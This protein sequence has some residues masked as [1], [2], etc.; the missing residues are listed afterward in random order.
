[1]TVITMLIVGM[2]LAEIAW[3]QPDQGSDKKGKKE[4]YVTIEDGT[5][6]QIIE[7]VKDWNECD[8]YKSVSPC[9]VTVNM[10]TVPDTN[11]G[12]GAYPRLMPRSHWDVHVKPFIHL[13]KPEATGQAA[14][15][16]IRT[17]PFVTCTVSAVPGAPGR[18]LSANIGSLL[19]AVAGI[20]APAAPLGQLNEYFAP[21]SVPILTF[22]RGVG[23]TGDTALDMI[24]DEIQ[25]RSAILDTDYKAI[26][27]GYKNFPAAVKTYWKFTFNDEAAADEAIKQLKIK[28]KALRDALDQFN[29]D[30]EASSASEAKLKRYVNP[31]TGADKITVDNAVLG[32]AGDLI[33]VKA[34]AD[35]IKARL[36]D[37][38]DRQKLVLQVSDYLD[39]W[40]TGGVDEKT[41]RTIKAL[42]MAYFSG[43]TVTETITCKDAITKDPA[44][45]NIIFAAYYE[46]LLHIDISVGAI[47]SLLG[48]RQVGSLTTPFTPAQAAACTTQAA[49]GSMTPCGPGTLLGYTSRS[50]YQFMP[51]VFVEWR[52]K[53][54]RCPGVQNGA[55]WHPTGYLCSIGVAGGVAI[56][57]N[58][59]GPAAEFFEGISIGV[60]RFSIML[61]VHNGR[62]QEYGG[63]YYAGEVFPTGTSVTPPTV[64]GWATHPAFAIGYRI[65]LR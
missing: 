42:P 37:F 60:Q 5:T 14:V 35:L 38:G 13:N 2:G 8:E 39:K 4:E 36:G 64:Y 49:A 51:G 16:L 40:L 63:G 65:P 15:W 57:P 17:S 52:M 19:T 18:D 21:L 10:S 58:N 50:S 55:P 61:G 34:H 47:G 11:P 41:P 27:D 7:K 53:N 1:M 56:N 46:A 59:G 29:L 20:G 33:Q 54:F 3:G 26:Q 9:R 25:G 31:K 12:T 48:G 32:A 43:K 28:V 62:Y 30:V 44:F 23:T 45:D 22:S 6:A 24:V